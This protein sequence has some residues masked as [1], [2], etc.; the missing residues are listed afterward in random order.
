M[1]R[2]MLVE[3]DTTLSDLYHEQGTNTQIVLCPQ[4]LFTVYNSSGVK[5]TKYLYYYG[6][7]LNRGLSDELLSK[8]NKLKQDLEEATQVLGMKGQRNAFAAGHMQVVLFDT[9]TTLNR[10]NGRDDTKETFS[11]LPPEQ[12]PEIFYY[13]SLE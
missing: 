1:M 7:I 2:N 6:D 8:R 10:N 11:A 5:S 12:R 3:L 9:T 4:P 13:S